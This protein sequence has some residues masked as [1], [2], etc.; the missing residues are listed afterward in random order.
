M[1]GEGHGFRAGREQANGEFCEHKIAILRA[2]H[3]AFLGGGI[4]QHFEAETRDEQRARQR[5][6]GVSFARGRRAARDDG[7]VFLGLQCGAR[8]GGG[9]GRSQREPRR[10]SLR[11][12]RG[13]RGE[14][15]SAGTARVIVARLD[16]LGVFRGPL[17]FCRFERALFVGLRRGEIF[18]RRVVEEGEQLIKFA[19]REG[20]VF[21]RVALG[22][23]ERH[24][25]PHGGGRAHAVHG[26]LAAEL[27]LI[28]AA[29][30]VRECLSVKARGRLFR[31][32]RAGQEV[33]GEL[34]NAE[35]IEGHVVV[36]RANHPIAKHVGV[37]AD[38]VFLVTIA[39][40]VTRKIKP[41]PAPALAEMRRTQ[42]PI[43]EPFVGV[44][45]RVVNE[46]ADFL[47]LRRQAEQIEAQAANQ[48]V[49]IGFG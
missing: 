1:E 44:R 9:F 41:V 40:G 31:E 49:A 2:T 35:T 16:Q 36:D 20:V 7:A 29:L 17:L 38:A 6:D 19:L 45:A 23:T 10:G 5:F 27:L 32:S 11:R 47:R 30:G 12:A 3:G 26:G 4:G 24:A 48:R 42:Q 13:P 37:R 43:H 14:F 18:L 21:V 28:G 46:L 39:V 25:E 15:H 33:A 34:Q 22:A 8:G